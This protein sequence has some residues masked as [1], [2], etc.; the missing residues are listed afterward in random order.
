MKKH[1]LFLLSLV[2]ALSISAQKPKNVILLIG[3]GMGTTQF[4]TMIAMNENNAIE[5]FPHVSFQKT[6]AADNFVTESG[7]AATALATGRKTNNRYISVD[8]VTKQPLKTLV[9]L[10]NAKGLSTGVVVTCDITHATPAAFLAHNIDRRNYEAIAESVLNTNP[11][12]FIGGGRRQFERRTDHRNLSD[13]LRK[14]GFQLLYTL[15]DFM[16]A[17]NPKIAGLLWDRHPENMV[18]GRGDFLKPASQK[19][20]ELLNQNSKG[21][22]LMI[23]SS[24]VD[25][26]CHDNNFDELLEELKDFD[27]TI[28]AVMDF[29]RKD[30][31]T[32]VI[33]TGDHETG[34]LAVLKR[35]GN[36]LF[37]RWTTFD[38]SPVMVPVFAFGPGAEKFSG[39]Y[40]N[41]EIQKK[42]VELLGL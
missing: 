9:Q 27:E 16:R 37:P 26:I 38:H 39:V 22:F 40:E 20:I 19:A 5:Q 21:F 30:G 25:W 34:G 41:T 32:L 23:E 15:D 13:S 2:F 14:Q 29:A 11:T 4:F 33:V 8:P 3:D 18:N 7:A 36:V 31:N 10:S 12:L 35:E 24:Q 28:H 1:F 17:R 42:I 6:A